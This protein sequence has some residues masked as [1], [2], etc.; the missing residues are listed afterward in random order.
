VLTTP[1]RTRTGSTLIDDEVLREAEVID[2]A[3]YAV[4]GVDADLDPDIF[5]DQRAPVTNRC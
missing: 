4:S 5:M 1:S 2:F 3:R